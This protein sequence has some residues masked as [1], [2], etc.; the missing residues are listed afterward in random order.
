M[1]LKNPVTP[2]L[3]DPGTLRLVAQLLNHYATSTH[4]NKDTTNICSH[5]TTLLTT[6]RCTIMDYF[7]RCNFSKHE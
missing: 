4:T 5:T 3:V 2:P 1:S 7:N 6:H